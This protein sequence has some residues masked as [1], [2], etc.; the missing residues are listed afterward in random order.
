MK[1][2]F[3]LSFGLLCVVALGCGSGEEAP[4][5]A[6]SNDLVPV[7]AA[8]RGEGGGICKSE[9]TGCEC[10]QVG[11][12]V[13]CLIYRTSGD[14]TSCEEGKRICSDA[15]RWTECIGSRIAQ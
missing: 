2:S 8:P 4:P 11:K 5:P 14:Y 6:P 10:A 9:N 13:E 12:E 15:G 1:T 3:G 7:D